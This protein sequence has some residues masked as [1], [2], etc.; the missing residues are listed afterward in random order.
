MKRMSKESHRKKRRINRSPG[1]PKR[2]KSSFPLKRAQI[3]KGRYTGRYTGRY[4]GCL[5]VSVFFL[6]IFEFE[7]AK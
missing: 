7:V 3:N 6:Q 2:V 1:V 5:P 4:A